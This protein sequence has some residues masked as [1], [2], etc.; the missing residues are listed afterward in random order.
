MI[1]GI[2]AYIDRTIT[3]PECEVQKMVIIGAFLWLKLLWVLS[4]N[5]E[6]KN[7]LILWKKFSYAVV[8]PN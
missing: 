4:V 2:M 5:D 8:G 7:V 1:A 6:L 3:L